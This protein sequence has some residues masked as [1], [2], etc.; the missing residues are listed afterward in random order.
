MDKVNACPISWLQNEYYTRKAKNPFYSL[1]AFAKKIGLPP[2]RLSEILTGKR[3]L[4][5][6]T[7]RKIVKSLGYDH[8]NEQAKI[9]IDL[10]TNYQS[11]FRFQKRPLRNLPSTE[12]FNQYQ[13]T[14]DKFEL[15]SNWYYYGI[16]NL[17]HTRGFKDE[18]KWI[19]N[20]LG[21]STVDVKMAMDTL[22]RLGLIK[23]EK[24][25]VVRSKL[26]LKTT[27]D[28]P[29]TAIKISH[30]QNILQAAEA[31][32][33]VPVEYRDIT[34]IT[35]PIDTKLIPQAKS[36]IKEFRRSMAKFLDQGNKNEVYNLNIQLV[37]VTNLSEPA[38]SLSD[39][40]NNQNESQ[41]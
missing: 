14:T 22:K 1:R 33:T 5:L 13:L 12:S 25:K 15:I 11:N 40:V 29:S 4:T 8:N 30:K 21:I 34:S 17:I 9:L 10:I 6:I 36:L 31:L 39:S 28:I 37:P 24:D 16:L 7:G 19:A 38:T 20:R 3:N 2:G 26:N 18:P 32:F 23:K 27:E 35:V 41:Q